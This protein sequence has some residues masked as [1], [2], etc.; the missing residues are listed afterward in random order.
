[1]YKTSFDKIAFIYNFA[2]KYIAKDYKSSIQLIDK[3]LQLSSNH[4][5]IDIGG[6]TGLYSTH[7]IEKIDKAVI[8]DIS[9]KMLDKI[10]HQKILT[11]QADGAILPIKNDKFDIAIIIDVLHH[12]NKKDQEHVIKEIFRILK[13][14]GKAFF[15]EFKYDDKRPFSR[16]FIKIEQILT[17][18]TYH[19]KSDEFKNFLNENGFNKIK[20]TDIQIKSGKFYAI[21]TK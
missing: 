9:F 3:Y 7:I 6:G 11:I 15:I 5:V 20:M 17:G 16:F 18:K 14:G 13:K 4:C 2:V 12:I 21:A 10:D 19:L 8:V 1:V